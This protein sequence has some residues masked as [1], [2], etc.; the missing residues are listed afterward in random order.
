MRE[1]DR[2]LDQRDHGL[3]AT[4]AIDESTLGNNR[5]QSQEARLELG[6]CLGV[7]FPRSDV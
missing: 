3:Y 4:S 7:G 2:V 6:L 1:N 5:R